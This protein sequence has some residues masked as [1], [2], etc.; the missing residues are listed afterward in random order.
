MKENNN[1]SIPGERG[2]GSSTRTTSNPSLL[3]T[4]HYTRQTLLPPAKGNPPL[5]PWAPG[6]LCR[7]QHKITLRRNCL[8]IS[9]CSRLYPM[10]LEKQLDKT[11][12]AQYLLCIL[13]VFVQ[14]SRIAVK[15]RPAPEPSAISVLAEENCI[16]TTSCRL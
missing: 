11:V 7:S 1:T 13:T 14:I 10:G 15:L 8:G 3:H 12:G 6:R 16:C 9:S 2:K 4:P 5:F